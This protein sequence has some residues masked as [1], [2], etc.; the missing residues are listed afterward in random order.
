V[1]H[2]PL[3]A[4][5][6]LVATPALAADAPLQAAAGAAASGLAAAGS[7][8]SPPPAVVRRGDGVLTRVPGAGPR[9]GHGPLVR[10][11]VAVEGG[12]GLRAA[13]VVEEVEATLADPRSWGA[14]GRRS[15]QRVDGAAEVRIVLAS[16][17]TTDR[18]CAPIR[19]NGRFSCATGRL[20]VL[21]SARWLQG[22]PAYAGRLADYRRYVVNHE[23]GHVLGHGHASCPGRGLPAPV[24]VQQ[25]KG[26]GGCVAQPWPY[27]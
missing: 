10:Y 23:V 17:A 24:M 5:A 18:L 9:S 11:S 19:T 15:F 12:L 22:A 6:L 21:N 14:G 27:P 1:R 3:L 13:D 4:L 25:T 20:A 8:Q 26:T 7:A 16:P 2:A